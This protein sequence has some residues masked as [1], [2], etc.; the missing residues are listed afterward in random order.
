MEH[1]ILVV[2]ESEE[3][4]F[5]SQEKILLKSYL[6]L[7]EEARGFHFRLL[8]LRSFKWERC[9]DLGGKALSLEECFQVLKQPEIKEL[10]RSFGFRVAGSKSKLM[11]ELIKFTKKQKTLFDTAES[12]IIKRSLAIM[13]P[14][15]R[16]HEMGRQLFHRLYIIYFRTKIWPDQDK[17][18]TE[19]ILSEMAT[20]QY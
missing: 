18:M 1:M 7:S 4:L 11:D 6:T 15:C 5:G 3:H 20:R 12:L 17:F 16:L 13:G 10:C 19:F 14:L 9:N 2:L 8:N